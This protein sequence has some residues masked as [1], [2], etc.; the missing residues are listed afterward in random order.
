VESATS[1]IVDSGTIEQLCAH[2]VRAWGEL[3]V[4]ALARAWPVTA[5]TL[6]FSGS[7]LIS[8]QVDDAVC[9]RGTPPGTC[10][11][12]LGAGEW[13][14]DLFFDLLHRQPGTWEAWRPQ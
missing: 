11:A 10:A 6:D 3:M 12:Q 14:G 2:G 8:G 13:T 5:E 4:E 9:H 1:G 7:A